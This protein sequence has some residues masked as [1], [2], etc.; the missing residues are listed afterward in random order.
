[1]PPKTIEVTNLKDIPRPFIPDKWKVSN[2]QEIKADTSKLDEISQK[3]DEL[4]EVKVSNFEDI[5]Q[6]IVHKD[7]RVEN[8][9]EIKLDLAPLEKAIEKMDFSWP[10]EADDAIP[11]RLSDG[12]KFIEAFKTA[13]REGGE[14][15]MRVIGG[16]SGG[17]G[18]PAYRS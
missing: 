16:G 2:P 3:L 13:V 15:V 5:P 14:N 11:V 10:T 18:T 12:K 1:Q 9:D 17:A 4:K 6:V 8:L 7:V